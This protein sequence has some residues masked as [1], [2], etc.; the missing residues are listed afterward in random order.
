MIF[1]S[2]CQGFTPFRGYGQ[3]RQN[4]VSVEVQN[5]FNHV[6]TDRSGKINFQELQQAFINGN[7]QRYSE[8][9]CKLMISMFDTDRSGTI[10]VY[11][12]DKLFGFIKQWLA[13]F[14]AFDRDNS[15]SIEE[16]ELAQA[17][18]QMGFNFN[19]QFVTFLI[20]VNNPNKRSITID[21][22]IVLCI[23]VQ[24]FSDSF[25]QRDALGQG[26]ISI[27]FEDLV[28]IGLSSTN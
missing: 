9:A 23:K 12:F 20:G 16:G 21:Q 8:E 22:F 26:M 10:D 7:G 2:I 24:R 3:L 13:S 5:F 19:R 17:L 25:R 15:G 27:G 18:S 28:G 11:E 6:D 14:R 4:K 1:V